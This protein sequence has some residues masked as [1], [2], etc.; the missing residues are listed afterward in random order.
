MAKSLLFTLFGLGRIPAALREEADRQ[1]IILIDEGVRSTVTFHNYRSPVRYS[2]LRIQPFIG[3]VILT[4][5][6]LWCLNEKLI[7]VRVPF[8][9]KEILSR[10]QLFVTD[11]N[12]LSVKTD[13]SNYNPAATGEIRLV[14]STDLAGAFVERF[15]AL[16]NSSAES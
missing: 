1:G 13:A 15:N 4:K 16:K 11:K 2:G 3:T 9:R 12:K 5:S 6:C 7:R 10:T 14:F 8:G